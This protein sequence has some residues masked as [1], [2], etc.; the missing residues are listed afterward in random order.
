MHR[1]STLSSRTIGVDP[2]LLVP[3]SNEEAW[4]ALPPVKSGGGGP[5]PSWAR[6]LARSLPRTT[7]ALLHLDLAQRTRSPLDPKLRAAMRW[8]AARANE[9]PYGMVSAEFDARIS[10]VEDSWFSAIRDDD[11]SPFSPEERAALGFARKMTVESSKVTD[12]EFEALVTAYGAKKAAAMVLLMAYANFQD[13]LLIV[14]GAPVEEDG[15]IPPVEVS[16]APESLS[17]HSPP[18]APPAIPDLPE[19]TGRGLIDDPAGWTVFSYDD[20]QAKLQE[21][22]ARPTRLP[23]P[24]YEEVM[25]GLPP[26]TPMHGKRVVWTLVAFGYCPELAVPWETLMWVNGAENGRRLDR[27]FGLGL[28]WVVTRTIDCPYCMGHVE[29]NWEV[30]GMKPDQI[31]ERSR[32]LS[33]K[34]WSSFPAEEQRALSLARKLTADPAGVTRNDINEVV[35]DFGLD[36]AVSLLTYVCRCNYMVRVSNGFQL[37]LERD[38]V[39]FDYYRIQ[40]PEGP[41]SEVVNP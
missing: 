12:E 25:K 23:V 14:L 40:P 8:V 30:I 39:F 17:A 4:Q 16:F 34:D 32:A 41:R 15:P 3:F 9:S 19:P 27:V 1:T 37:S 20:L 33:G 18:V 28:F 5:L 36:P 35:H 7:A 13:R 29:M 22:R 24:S 6:I 38:N 10:G 2:P 21:Q 31:A 26:G 11:L